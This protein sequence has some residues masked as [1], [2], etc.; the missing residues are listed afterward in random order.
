V[1]TTESECTV[2]GTVFGKSD[3]RIVRIDDFR[4]E[5]IPEGYLALIHNLDQPG[6]IGSIGSTLGENNINISGMQVGRELGGEHNIILIRTDTPIPDSV[7]KKILS[8]PKIKT[9]KTLEL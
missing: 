9:I 1:I 5:I 2:A 8:L 4:I 3:A 6:A 7:I